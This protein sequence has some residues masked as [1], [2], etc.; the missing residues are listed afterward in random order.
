VDSPILKF[1][2]VWTTIS[3]K[4]Q[5]PFLSSAKSDTDKL[6]IVLT[7]AVID[8]IESHGDFNLPVF[9]L[10]IATTE[11]ENDIKLYLFTSSGERKGY[12]IS[13]F[14]R[15]F[16]TEEYQAGM[17]SNNPVLGRKLQYLARNANPQAIPSTEVLFRDCTLSWSYAYY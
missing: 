4:R 2:V 9:D 17:C 10:T 14:P 13:G 5:G 3:D 8:R 11:S 6:Q 12:S 16:L 1:G 15:D 7:E